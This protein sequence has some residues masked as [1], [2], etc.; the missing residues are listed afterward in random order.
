MIQFKNISL[1]RGEKVLFKAVNFAIFD[2]QKVGLIGKNGSG[3]SSLFSLLTN[4]LESDTG[5]IEASAGLHIVSVKQE[6]DEL[7]TPVIDYVIRGAVRLYDLKLKMQQALTEGDY[8]RHAELL[9]DFEVLGGYRI[10]S[11]AAEIL[12]GL[13][14]ENEVIYQAVRN[15]SGGWRIRL[16]LAQA[17]L[18]NGD[19]LLLDEPTNHLDLD[20]VMWLEQYLKNFSGALILISHDRVFLDN[21][22][23]HVLYI[24]NQTITSFTGNFSQFEEQYHQQRLL[25]Q[26]AFD[27][28]QT[29]IAHLEKF[30]NRFKA[31]A[32]KAKQAQSRIKMLEKMERIEAVSG[33]DR[34]HFSFNNEAKPITSTLVQ[35]DEANCGYDLKTPILK[36]INLAI[37]PQQRIGLLGRNG[38]GK[39]TLIK[40]LVGDI[41]L[42]SG[43]IRRHPDLKIGYFAQHSMDALDLEASSMAHFERL[44]P[45][46]A[47]Q[48][49]R[50][51]LG[52]F[53]FVGNMAFNPI[54]DFSGGEK[55]R[56]ALALI[57]YQNPNFLL[58]DEPTNHLD[59]TVKEALT[60]ALQGFEGAL[61]V[62]SHDRFLLES[63]VDEYWLVD[64]GHVDDF[65]G[66]LSDYY[67]YLQRR[68]LRDESS[69][70][71]PVLAQNDA[72]KQ[73]RQ[74][75]A[76]ARKALKLITDELKK[77][78]SQMKV[79]SD[80]ISQLTEEMQNPSFYED[81]IKIE[82][83][84]I[85]LS[86]KKARLEQKENRWLE[87]SEQLLD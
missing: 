64:N 83:A 21:V 57:V 45:K 43:G 73:D 53:N 37:M 75:R 27:K 34:F 2:R 66:D 7:D 1:Q 61:I 26:K 10:E 76:K 41:P 20:A 36:A 60:Q 46:A 28:Q 85:R 54:C 65:D 58:L 70:V 55:A 67:Q 84:I 78:E 16:N 17:L 79:L 12:A 82:Q 86:D 25:Q 44:D 87:L 81:K 50:S 5:E 9:A 69:E 11:K 8:L 63:T 80:E 56:L 13:G 29:H 18:E 3:K 52:R 15:L 30:V 31:K 48:K 72:K 47:P 68:L 14:F 35:L 39:S 59:M 19:V 74:Q 38:A 24:E 42:L 32:S 33:A 40:S 23:E 22:I 62:V 49:L 71:E 4:A 77:L 51:F 6:V